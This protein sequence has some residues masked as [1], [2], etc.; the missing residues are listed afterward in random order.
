MGGGGV[1]GREGGVSWCQ[2]EMDYEDGCERRE[3]GRR[4]RVGIE[5]EGRM[6]GSVEGRLWDI[7]VV[8]VRKRGRA[9]VMMREGVWGWR[10]REE[11]E[12]GEGA[13]DNVGCTDG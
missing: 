11:K 7:C 2:R 13:I 8:I 6:E 1:E 10:V 4:G 9:V 5:G 3:R 12:A